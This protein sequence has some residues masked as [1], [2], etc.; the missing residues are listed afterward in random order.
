MHLDF[1]RAL[2]QDPPGE[3]GGRYVSVYLDTTPTTANAEAQVTLRWQ[4]ARERLA[5]AGAD[6]ATLDAVDQTATVL[7]H[8]VRGRVIFARDG[9]TWLEGTLPWP[10]RQEL[11]N[12]APLPHVMPWLAQLPARAPHVR[13]A[14]TK[15]GG[16][17][18]AVTAEGAL[19]AGETTVEGVTWPVHKVSSGGWSQQRLQRS[20]EETWA[21]N[22]KRTVA[23]AV[24]E[25]E[26]VHAEFVLVGGD[27]RERS[28]VL[29]S[30]P[31][32][33][34]ESA[35]IVDKEVAADDAEFDAAAEAEEKRMA[36]RTGHQLLDELAVRLEG[37]NSGTGVDE[38]RAV[39][40]LAG[41]LTALRDGLASDV[42]LIGEPA[43]LR[44][45]VWIGP[46]LAEAAVERAAL[47]DRGVTD[48][49]HGRADA[50]LARAVAGTDAQLH[51]L[52]AGNDDNDE[53]EGDPRAAEVTDGVAALLRA[54]AA[55]L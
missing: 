4:A 12:L 16:H 2:Y 33:L 32:A 22:A 14:A 45:A 36:A 38:R 1:L 19:E 43:W 25:A 29:D 13:V 34:R 10:P 20:T 48:P 5:E 55:A 53:A 31:P 46:G 24:A 27:V 18:L 35:V 54:P 11:A 51:L 37:S 49:L 40:G 52:F 3:F 7:D 23:V 44:E 26:R 41:A 39:T 8:T 47:A 6:E 50:A 28:M 30:L 15:E 17:V 9:A 42:L 21:T